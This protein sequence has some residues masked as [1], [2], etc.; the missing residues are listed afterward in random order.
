[1]PMQLVI[2]CGNFYP[3][4]CGPPSSCYSITS[5]VLA[6]FFTDPQFISNPLLSVISQAKCRSYRVQ[7]H[8]VVVQPLVVHAPPY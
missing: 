1:M 3:S 5:L 4:L 2:L 7:T 6:V 8:P